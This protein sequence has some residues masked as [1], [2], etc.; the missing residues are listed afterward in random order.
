MAFYRG[1]LGGEGVGGV[2]AEFGG[3]DEGVVVAAAEVRV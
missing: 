1:G 2:E 3:A